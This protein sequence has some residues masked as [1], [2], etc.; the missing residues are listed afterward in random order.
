MPNY[1]GMLDNSAS[2]ILADSESAANNA[3]IS[4]LLSNA[5]TKATPASPITVTMAKTSAP[6]SG[7]TKATIPPGLGVLRSTTPPQVQSKLLYK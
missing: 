5:A 3:N 4:V 2:L 6:S 7:K 1:L